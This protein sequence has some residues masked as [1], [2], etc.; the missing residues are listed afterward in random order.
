[1][2]EASAATTGAW[3]PSI[4]EI[5]VDKVVGSQFRGGPLDGAGIVAVQVTIGGATQTLKLPL[6]QAQEL[7]G[8]LK[9]LGI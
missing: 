2:A 8:Q 3:D 9:K 6:A 7:A 1:M 5:A 4:E